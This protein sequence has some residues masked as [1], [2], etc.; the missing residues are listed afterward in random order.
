MSPESRELE[1]RLKLG[2]LSRVDGR[3]EELQPLFRN[4][5]FQLMIKS[6][7]S[8]AVVPQVFPLPLIAKR[9]LKKAL[10]CVRIF[11]IQVRVVG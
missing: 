6:V 1:S 8:R 10:H 3:N 5:Y 2:D 9:Q 11:H 7:E 4:L